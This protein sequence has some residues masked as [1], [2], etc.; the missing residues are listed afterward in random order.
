MTARATVR[1]PKPL[2]NIPMTVTGRPAR[3]RT[4][5]VDDPLGPFLDDV[6]IVGPRAGGEVLPAA[7]ADDR[8]QNALVEVGRRANRCGHDGA[9]RDA[10]EHADFGEPA[11]PLDGL[12]G[13][14]DHLAV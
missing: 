4:S 11:G 2:S 9:R 13:T 1:P 10:G 14:D 8:D 6:E 12:A 5:E 3:R 7:V